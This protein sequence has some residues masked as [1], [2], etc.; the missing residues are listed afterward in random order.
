MPRNRNKSEPPPVMTWA[1]ATPILVVAVIFDALRLMFTFFWFFG[2]AIT[3]VLCTVAVSGTVG[4]TIG[5]VACSTFA[6]VGGFVA[7][8]AITAFGVVMA[9]ATGFA[10]WGVVGGWLMMTNARIFKENALL[11]VASLAICEIPFIGSIPAISVAMWRMHHVQIKKEKA[12][13]KRYEEEQAAAQLKERQQQEAQ[14]QY[15]AAQQAQF[16]KQEAA[17][18]AAY[19]EAANDEIPEEVRRRA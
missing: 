7:A 14:F 1:K 12:A 5:G 17:N 9:M 13:L 8:P 10:G 3:A 16:A 2:P 18:D 11:F 6:A 4:A 19:A 15:Q